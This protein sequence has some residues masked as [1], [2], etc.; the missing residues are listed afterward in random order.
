M[1][2]IFVLFAL[3]SMAACSP[4]DPYKKLD[5][6]SGL[7]QTHNSESYLYEEWR[8]VKNGPFYGKSYTMNGRD[9]IVF[10]RVEIRQKGDSIYYIPTLTD[11]PPVPFA[12][13]AQKDYSFTFEN[14]QHDF[15]QRVIYRFVGKDSLVARIE[16]INKGEAQSQEFY[17]HRVKR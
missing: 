15:P 9:S 8:K 2:K 14:K 4:D 17:Y 11:Q 1:K 13:V 5:R 6:L 3:A 10:E 16:G 12:L 7:W